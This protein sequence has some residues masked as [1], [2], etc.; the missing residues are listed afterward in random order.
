MYEYLVSTS[1]LGSIS[2]ALSSR[3]RPSRVLLSRT[4]AGDR[5]YLRLTASGKISQKEVTPSTIFLF[6]LLSTNIISIHA[7]GRVNLKYRSVSMPMSRL[8]KSP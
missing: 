5:V 3:L 2:A 7:L 8:E 4:A 6:R 1:G